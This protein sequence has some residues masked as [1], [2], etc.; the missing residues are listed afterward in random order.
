MP[1][2]KGGTTAGGR[3]EPGTTAGANPGQTTARH[4]TG[5]GGTAA[6]QRTPAPL[7]EGS[8]RQQRRATPQHE[9]HLGVTATLSHRG[10]D[11]SHRG[12]SDSHR[13]DKPAGVEGQRKP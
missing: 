2:D 1:P 8:S 10:E 11:G 4:L 3:P 9:G 7:K 6:K 12:E 13:D 5:G